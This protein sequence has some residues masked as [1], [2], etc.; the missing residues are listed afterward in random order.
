VRNFRTDIILIKDTDSYSFDLLDPD[1]KVKFA[2]N[3][4][5]STTSFFS[6][7]KKNNF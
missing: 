6:N 2:C 3:E 4:N 1:L 5:N 7:E